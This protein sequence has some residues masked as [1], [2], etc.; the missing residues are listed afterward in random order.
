[1]GVLRTRI[2]IVDVHGRKIE[3]LAQQAP[4][5]FKWHVWAEYCDNV[6]AGTTELQYLGTIIPTTEDVA[7]FEI[8]IG[9]LFAKNYKPPVFS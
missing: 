1:M 9:E 3:S 7:E 4:R 5:S 2:S 6:N 8:M